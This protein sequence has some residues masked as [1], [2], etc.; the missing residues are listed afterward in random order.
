MS[1]HG[2]NLRYWAEKAGCLVEEIIDFS[3]NLNPLVAPLDLSSLLVRNL[4]D[5]H[6][7]PDPD[8]KNLIAAIKK[9]WSLPADW[10][11]PGNGTSDLLYHLLA[12]LPINRVVIPTPSYI[13]YEKAAQAADLPICFVPLAED[14]DFQPDL[15]EIEENLQAGDLLI[16]GQPNNPT[17]RMVDRSLFLQMAARNPKTMFLVDEAFAMFVPGYKSMAGRLD[18]VLV[19]CSLTKIFAIAGL[20]LGFLAAAPSHCLRIKEKIG[21]WS[22]NSLALAAGESFLSG[23]SDFISLSQQTILR[24]KN[25]MTARL[26][27]IKYLSVVPAAANFLLVKISSAKY[28]NQ[29]LADYLLQNH[30]IAIRLCENYHQLEGKNYFRVAIRK[31][32]END[33]LLSAMEEFFSS[34][35]TPLQNKLPNKKK[36]PSLMFLG[37]GSDVGKS[38][39]MAGLA[40]IMLQDGL[41]V[42]PFKSQNMSLNSFVTR[43]GGEM[44]RAQVVQAQACRLEPDVRMNPVLLKPN[45]DVGSQVIVMG[46]AVANMRVREFVNYKEKLWQEVCR[47]YDELSVEYDVVL[48]EGAG[49][50][51]E[52]NLKAHD[53]VNCKMARYAGA[54]TLLVGDIDRGGVFASFMGHF[55][56]ME[57]WERELLAGFLINRFRGDASLLDA[58]H[59]YMLTSTGKKVVGVVPYI[60]NL[61]LPQEDSVG[62][63]AGLFSQEKPKHD[64]VE[65]VL[66]DLPHISNF[67]DVEPFLAEEDVYLRVVSKVTDVGRADAFIIPGSKNVLA[68]MDFLQQSGLADLLLDRVGE[69]VEIVGICGGFQ[70]LGK[71]INDPHGLESEKGATV[72]GLSL[73]DMKTELARQKTLLRKE[74]VHKPSGCRVY[75]YEIHHGLSSSC[76][77]D[78]FLFSDGSSCGLENNLVWGCYL[79]GVFD[80][81][82]FRR[83][84][85]NRLRKN[86]GLSPLVS[87]SVYDIEPALDRLADVLRDSIDLDFVYKSMGL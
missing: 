24:E 76:S 42:V 61:D 52:V 87:G 22:V 35:K 83:W 64:F 34:K 81:D 47:V 30:K 15:H 13:D 66:L 37:T 26:V 23:C 31:Q 39:L 16:I 36:T 58:A 60:K 8:C 5:L 71:M 19:L 21:P 38:V 59:D 33:L 51:G 14:D 46:K 65:V 74:G 17:G 78:L 48:L 12:T 53:I 18:N 79:H 11:L 3:A 80:S 57:K 44:G 28:S 73:L 69:G 85:I 55:L 29:E 27:Q 1:G 75:G 40:R 82:D 70:M 63:K 84:W 4:D 2:G 9:V 45:S 68:D 25:R 50:A 56:V 49:S 41:S 72:R 77:D 86:K 32:K 20:R 6:H 54:K 62:F 43:D 67:T 10:V 7:Y